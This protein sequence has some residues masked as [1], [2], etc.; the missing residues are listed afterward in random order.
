MPGCVWACQGT[1]RA[2]RDHCSKA[3]G[4]VS[5]VEMTGDS[6]LE[7]NRILNVP[8][9]CWKQMLGATKKQQHSGKKFSQQGNLLL[10]KDTACTS[11]DHKGTLNKGEKRWN[12]TVSPKLEYRWLNLGSLQ[13][14]PPGSSDSSA[15]GV[16]WRDLSSLQ[17]QSLRFKHFSCLSLP[18]MRFCHVAQAGLELMASSNLPKTS[19]SQSAGIKFA[20]VSQAGVQWHD[21]GSLHPPPPGFKWSLTVSPRLECS[22]IILAHCNLHLTGSSDP[23]TSASCVAGITGSRHHAWLIFVF[24]VEMGFHHVDRDGVLPCW[25]GWSR[26][27][28]LM[29]HP[30]W[31]PKV[32]GLEA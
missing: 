26:T 10:Q 25:S 18:K 28:D 5:S 32:L 30:P 2:G 31:P 22:D 12:L 9:D 15:A 17:C 8:P 13:P 20:L 1:T 29:I 27:P 16:E 11:H 4:S 19:A 6:A 7:E 23:P 14:L 24:L 3:A 21:L